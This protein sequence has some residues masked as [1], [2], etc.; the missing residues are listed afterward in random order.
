MLFETG[1]PGV[2]GGR[3]VLA[4]GFDAADLQAG[5]LQDVGGAADGPHVHVGRDVRLDEG[6]SA[7]CVGAAGH[8][9]DQE[10][11][12]GAQCGVQLGGEG[13]ILGVADVFAHLDG[14]GRVVPSA[15]DVAP[16]P[17]LDLHLS[18]HAL[19]DGP[20]GDEVPLLP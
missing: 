10:P 11:A 18:G 20:L 5:G 2:D 7:G 15:V 9:L 3:V 12:L 8:L 14:T 13:G 17:Q 19:A 4:Q 1:A 6:S 16:V